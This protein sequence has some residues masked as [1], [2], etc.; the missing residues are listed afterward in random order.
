MNASNMPVAFVITSE[1]VKIE[2]LGMIACIHGGNKL[3]CITCV[4]LCILFLAV[5]E[6]MSE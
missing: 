6:K 4:L 5:V 3:N 1:T 2:R